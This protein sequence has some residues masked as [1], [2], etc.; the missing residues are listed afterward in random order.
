M[1]MKYCLFGEGGF[2]KKTLFLHNHLHQ[3]PTEAEMSIG[4]SIT[5][6]PL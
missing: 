1:R 2:V 5:S 6:K 4:A 3:S